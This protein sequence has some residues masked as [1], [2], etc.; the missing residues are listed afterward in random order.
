MLRKLYDRVMTLGLLCRQRMGE[1]VREVRY[2][3]VVADVE[4][5]ARDV[6]AFLGLE[7][8][9]AML[10]FRDAALKRNINTPS[11][12]QVVEPIYNRSVARWHVDELRLNEGRGIDLA[13]DAIDRL[14]VG[15]ARPEDAELRQNSR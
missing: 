6:T 15:V 3:D 4:H 8:E 2:E 10:G 14:N 12:R 13:L 5:V 7:F 11:A 1:S 9:P